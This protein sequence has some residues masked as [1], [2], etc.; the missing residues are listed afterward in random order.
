M[1]LFLK[2]SLDFISLYFQSLPFRIILFLVLLYSILVFRV[3]LPRIQSLESNLLRVWLLTVQGR[4][5][6]IFACFLF[7]ATHSEAM[8]PPLPLTFALFVAWKAADST[9]SK[10]HSRSNRVSSTTWDQI[11]LD[12]T[13]NSSFS[14]VS[15]IIL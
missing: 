5:R 1:P 2:L 10:L 3:I 13:E 15:L 14:L 6:L 12:R 7:V 9:H 4:L 11:D 8:V